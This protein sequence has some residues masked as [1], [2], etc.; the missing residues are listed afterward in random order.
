M[1]TTDTKTS[2]AQPAKKTA[3][4]FKKGAGQGFFK[5]AQP[6]VQTKLTIGEPGDVYEKEADQM[7]DQVVKKKP[8]EGAGA[9]TGLSSEMGMAKHIRRKP[10]FESK[11][12]PAE[13][14]QRKCASCEKEEGLQRKSEG[15]AAGAASASVEAG[16]TSTKGSGSALSPT[17]LS[18][19]EPAFGADLSGVRIHDNSSA[20]Q[21]NKQ[22]NAQAFTHGK[23]IYFDSGKYKP[24]N[25]DGQH[26][27][28]HELTH[29]VQQT[30]KS[31][32]KGTKSEKKVQRKPAK[33]CG[34]T[35]GDASIDDVTKKC[36]FPGGM[37]SRSGSYT[38][39]AINNLAV[40]DNVDEKYLAKIKKTLPFDLPAPGDRAKAPTDQIGMWTDMVKSSVEDKIKS[41]IAKINAP[42]PIADKIKPENLYSLSLP[43]SKGI[44]KLVGNYRNLVDECIVPKWS[45]KGKG[46][47]FQ[48]EHIMD[49]QIAGDK[50]DDA[51]NLM[52]LNAERNRDLGG[53]ILRMI[54]GKIQDI[55]DHYNQYIPAGSL[56]TKANEA[57]QL[58]KGRYTIQAASLRR[59]KNNFAQDEAILEDYMVEKTME[60]LNPLQAANI[61]IKSFG[62]PKVGEF[63]LQSSKGGTMITLPYKADDLQVGSYLLTMHGSEAKG[64]TK[65]TAVLDLAGG[66]LKGDKP[67][68]KEYAV[69]KVPG[70]TKVF[71]AEKFGYEMSQLEINYL[72]LVEFGDP[73]LDSE[74]NLHITGKIN[75]PTPGFL[76]GTPIDVSINGRDLSLEKTFA[77]SELG[78]VGPINVDDAD[79]TIG[80]SLNNGFTVG[81]GVR[82]S[83][84]KAGKGHVEA[85]KNG[86]G[87]IF[88]GGFDFDPSTFDKGNI[89]VTYDSTKDLPGKNPWTF[90]GTLVIGK[91]VKGIDSATIRVGYA[92][93]QLTFDGSAA[94]NVPGVKSATIKG[95]YRNGQDF[96]LTLGA[97]FDFKN[98]YIQD[99]QIEV[100]L[101]SGGAPGGGAGGDQN[102]GWRLSLSGGMTLNVPKLDAVPIAVS[103]KDG[104]FDASAK[105]SNIKVGEHVTGSVTV[106]VTNKPVD[107]TTGEAAGGQGGGK[108][109]RLYGSGT[110]IVVFNEHLHSTVGVRL[111]QEGKVLVNGDVKLDKQP[112]M[113][114]NKL[115][116]DDY[117]LFAIKSPD[118]PVF[119]IGVGDVYI[120]FG[121]GADANYNIGVPLISADVNLKDVDIHDP[122]SMKVITTITPEI[123]ASAGVR[124]WG[125]F[126]FGARVA[127]LKAEGTVTGSIGL[128]AETTFHP[129]LVLSWSPTEGLGFVSAGVNLDADIKAAVDLTGK[130]AVLLDFYFTTV[131]VWDKTWD[132]GHMDLG[133]LGKLSLNF[134][135]NFG[136][137]GTPLPPNRLQPETPFAKKDTATDWMLNKPGGAEKKEQGKSDE[138]I[139]KEVQEDIRKLP[140]IGPRNPKYNQVRGR[141]FHYHWLV[142]TVPMV[143]WDFFR[144]VWYEVEQEEFEDFK[145]RV[146]QPVSEPVSKKEQ[147][148]QFAM[149]HVMV[150]PWQIVALQGEVIR[151]EAAAQSS[152]A[153]E[154]PPADAN[155]SSQSSSAGNQ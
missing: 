70:T 13:G 30:G 113:K 38:T 83:I 137:D 96:S 6:V 31:A 46:M 150:Q 57:Q 106:G 143:N 123:T 5:P 50:A 34:L 21:L 72:S 98:K 138:E 148:D 51:A 89:T 125:S 14:L 19:M 78:K 7:A 43:N 132:L 22:L 133:E 109:L 99:P 88:K 144:K 134:P 115:Y 152:Q 9:G 95:S 33:T 8:A 100:T 124:L 15:P 62:K 79:L 55:L 52:L 118:I 92:D 136:K 142:S 119:S 110:I 44:T 10:I 117:P 65:I 121:G 91:K 107:E 122:S 76:N 63:L 68:V 59:V 27:L 94:L 90:E 139:Q 39:I 145:D 84:P 11:N 35:P 81:G 29:V 155:S 60:K 49:Y 42:Q 97:A 131:N 71:R 108:D 153:P 149:D 1:K 41:Y 101:A 58:A 47:S 114:G 146:L 103:Y 40:K 74:L 3:P 116:G 87:F 77:A 4:F 61:D 112:L 23:D 69:S 48:V 64:L 56:E 128:T 80:L 12:D 151:L 32:K 111:T 54:R 147:V 16:I 36:P 93:G 26:L 140:A 141:D 85:S 2:A 53:D 73:V 120:R 154:P 75:K 24:Q 28:A 18:H 45:I 105:V 102:T 130:V 17:T 37:I 20:H 66:V 104:E 67:P 25:T 82:F 135:L 129:S 126:T 86:K 127:V